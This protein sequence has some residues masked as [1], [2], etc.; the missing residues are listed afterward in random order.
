MTPLTKKTPSKAWSGLNFW[1]LPCT[2]SGLARRL[3]VPSHH[4]SQVLNDRF[5]KSFHDVVNLARVE[6]L[7]RRLLDRDLSAEKI[8]ALGMDC[9]F[10]S[11]STLNANFKKHTG[12]TPS[13]FRDQV[14]RTALRAADEGGRGGDATPP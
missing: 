7:K 10:S 11:K 4:L 6:E 3:G 12:L 13:Q 9:G 2:L 14:V 5:G 8:L 1:K